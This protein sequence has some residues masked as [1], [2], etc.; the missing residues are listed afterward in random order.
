LGAGAGTAITSGGA[1]V[2]DRPSFA[3]IVVSSA[4]PSGSVS[5]Y[6]TERR[7]VA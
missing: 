2:T 3:K 6:V 7:R 1:L 4:T 5:P